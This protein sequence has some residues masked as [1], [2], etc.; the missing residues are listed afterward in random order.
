MLIGPWLASDYFRTLPQ[1]AE[2]DWIFAVEQVDA[3]NY[4]NT[5]PEDTYVYWFGERWPY[6]HETFI[7]LAP[8]YRGET[9]SWEF[10]TRTDLAIDRADNAFVFIFIGGY[11]RLLDEARARYPQGTSFI[12]TYNNRPSF[13]AYNVGPSAATTTMP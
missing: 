9:R 12:S 2:N 3:I 10:K 1:S 7:Y 4:I 5:L 8:E 11:A 13:T 6:E